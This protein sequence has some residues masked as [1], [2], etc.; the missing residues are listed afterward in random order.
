MEI[1]SHSMR[2]RGLK[3]LD[4]VYESR[5]QGVALH[6]GAWIEI[7][8]RGY[9]WS[10]RTVALHAGAWIEMKRCPMRVCRLRSHSM[11]VRGLKLL[12]VTGIGLLVGVALHAGAWIEI[13]NDRCDWN[14]QS[15]ALHAGAWIEMT[16]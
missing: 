5:P 9:G 1:W 15:V 4:D 3:F 6:A 7:V 16:R 14:P 12:L 8:L 13:E 2:V 10:I 11:R